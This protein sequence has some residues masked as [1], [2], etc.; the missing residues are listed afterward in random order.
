MHAYGLMG[1]SVIGLSVSAALTCPAIAGE[2]PTDPARYPSKVVRMIIGF[3]PGG[4]VDVQARIIA[5]GLS[6]LLGQQ[7]IPDNRPGQDGIIAGLSSRNRRP[8][9]TP[10]SM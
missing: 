8:T 3:A 5:Q 2:G 9:V 6:E 4:A 1:R 10:S 7:V